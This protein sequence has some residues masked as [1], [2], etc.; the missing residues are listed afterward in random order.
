MVFQV[1]IVGSRGWKIDVS[2]FRQQQ[3]LGSIFRDHI[4]RVVRG[5]SDCTNLMYR[6]EFSTVSRI[7]VRD[8]T[9]IAERNY[10][11]QR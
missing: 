5:S 4:S 10:L 2:F 1:I 3:F 7:Q 11:W 6:T 8:G 9:S